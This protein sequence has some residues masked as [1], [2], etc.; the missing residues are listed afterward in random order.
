MDL[1]SPPF[2]SPFSIQ[3]YLWFSDGST[4]SPKGENREKEIE[5][6]RIAR[7]SLNFEENIPSISEFRMLSPYNSVQ[8]LWMKNQ[9]MYRFS[10]CKNSMKK[11]IEELY[12]W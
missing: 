10:Q 9:I 6:G 7:I 1:L 2:F 5:K 12:K 3:R 8:F 4:G 11:S